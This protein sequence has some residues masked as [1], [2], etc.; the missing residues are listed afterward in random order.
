VRPLHLIHAGA[1]RLFGGTCKPTVELIARG[2]CYARRRTSIKFR[3][4]QL[5]A[6][7]P[8]PVSATGK[9]SWNCLEKALARAVLAGVEIH[10]RPRRS[11]SRSNPRTVQGG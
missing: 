8:G 7:C 1:S 3:L 10:S 2:T 6:K 5:T 11:Q 9:E 4:I